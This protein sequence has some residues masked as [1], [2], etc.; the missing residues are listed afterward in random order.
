MAE[1][2][3]K[4]VAC[5]W[6]EL[7]KLE[8]KLDK[9]DVIWAAQKYFLYEKFQ[10]PDEDFKLNLDAVRAFVRGIGHFIS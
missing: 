4:R 10:F 6:K 8:R 2:E 9:G 3:H 5:K 7:C 1:K